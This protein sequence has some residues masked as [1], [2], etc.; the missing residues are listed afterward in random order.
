MVVCLTRLT[1]LHLLK[2]NEK[3]LIEKIDNYL[4]SDE[5]KHLDKKN[6]IFND[7]KSDKRDLL[8]NFYH[9]QCN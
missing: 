8:K 9:N 7:I 6:F 5:Y 2:K 3:E 4:K 1:A